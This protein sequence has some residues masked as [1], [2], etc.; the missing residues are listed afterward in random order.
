MWGRNWIVTQ[1]M[2]Q[3]TVPPK[4]TAC[5]HNLKTSN[6]RITYHWGAFVQLLL[7]WENSMYYIFWLCA[8]SIRYT[9]CN[10][11]APFCHLWPA[12][13][14]SIFPR[15]LINGTAFEEMLQIIKCVF[16]FSLQLLSEAFLIL[17]I[18]E[19]DMVKN[20]YWC[21]CK[22]LFILARF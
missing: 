16:W 19:W 18:N 21:S 20:V 7:Q 3:Y 13:L 17:R 11:H 15:H 4:N 22:V 8:C 1:F 5:F 12:R 9:A 10:A 6:V 14:Y 2:H